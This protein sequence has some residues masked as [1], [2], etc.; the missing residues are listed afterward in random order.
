MASRLTG[1]AANDDCADW[2]QAW[3]PLP[4]ADH[5]TPKGAAYWMT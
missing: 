4:N 3:A 5:G 2:Q 1:K